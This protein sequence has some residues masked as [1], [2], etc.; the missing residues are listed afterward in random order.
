MMS[1]VTSVLIVLAFLHPHKHTHMSESLLPHKCHAVCACPHVWS[2]TYCAAYAKKKK[3]KKAFLRSQ[4][5]ACVPPHPRTW[6]CK[7]LVMHHA[8]VDALSGRCW[9]RPRPQ[10]SLCVGVGWACG[11]ESWPLHRPTERV[12]CVT[13]STNELPWP[14]KT[15]GQAY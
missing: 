4:L 6:H 9:A 14:G 10:Q 13:C 3:K 5:R 15:T 12:R 1:Y 8:K 7:F 2:Q 11:S